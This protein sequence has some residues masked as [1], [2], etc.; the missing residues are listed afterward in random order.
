[1]WGGGK[2]ASYGNLKAFDFFAYVHV[3]QGQLAPRASKGV[4]IGY[5]KRVKGYKIYCIDLNSPKCIISRDV[6]FNE[7]ELIVKRLT[8]EGTNSSTKNS[9]VVEF[10]VEASSH[11]GIK[12]AA[13]SQD[14]DN[15][16][17]NTLE[18][19]QQT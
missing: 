13:D 4:F 11:R 15:D 7:Y 14:G 16:A 6:I 10:K 5:P 8:I 17:D 1:M 9:E 2:P 19:H 18:T 3:R 12:E